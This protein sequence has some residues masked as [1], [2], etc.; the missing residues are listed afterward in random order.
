MISNVYF[1]ESTALEM[2]AMTAGAT[3]VV[4]GV[5]MLPKDY[6][7]SLLTLFFGLYVFNSTT[8]GIRNRWL[9][10]AFEE[11]EEGEGRP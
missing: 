1:E 5:F 11:E 4:L 6:T 10:E 8:A 7:S 9:M 2:A 3:L